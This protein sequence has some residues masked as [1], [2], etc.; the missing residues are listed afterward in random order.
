[1]R[2][3]LILLAASGL[4]L[5]T[6]SP[7]SGPPPDD[8]ATIRA[9]RADQ[10]ASIAARN[11]DRV[12]SFWLEDVQVTAGL[13]FAFRGRDIYRR[14]FALDSSVTYRRE[15]EAI[16]VSSRWPLA[17]ENGTWTGRLAGAAGPPAISGRY[18]AQWI[19]VEGR[20]LIRSELFVALECTG[21]PC[22][23]PARAQ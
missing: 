16:V 23:W 14:A 17:W 8:A 22:A 20:W 9:A 11:L 3:H 13:G 12:A 7:R 10:N 19:K 18:S 4:A 6:F 21:S 2:A 5:V 1:L 15:P